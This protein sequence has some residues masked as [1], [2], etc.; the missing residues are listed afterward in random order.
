MRTFCT[1]ITAD[2][3]PKAI[4][5]FKSINKLEPGALLHIIVADNK[6]VNIGRFHEERIKIIPISDL[7]KYWL[8]DN[9]Y[10]KYAHIDLNFFR[11]SLKPIVINYLLEKGFE[12]VFYA[13]CDFYFF[14]DYQFLYDELDD[15]SVLLTP[16]WR[17]SDPLTDKSSFLA[18]FTS[19]VYSAGFIG[20]STRASP[21]LQWWANACHFMMGEQ[22]SLG[23]HDDQKYLDVLPVK[24]ESVKINRHRGCSLGAGNQQ[25]CERKLVSGEVLINGVYPIVSI[26]FDGLLIQEI[27]RGHDPLLLQYY[28][29]YKK[30]FEEDGARL[31]DFLA[32]VD[33]HANVGLL[34]RLKW[35]LNVRTRIK[36]VFYRLAARI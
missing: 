16:H 27:M 30:V 5:L 6:P 31:S 22:T 36:R 34:R 26:H 20:A 29:E 8:V 23:I 11:W 2:Y 15:C 35:K 19:G 25:E 14:S 33:T 17:N 24:F 28:E 13:D 9:L 10:K 3:Y 12:K 7:S 21:E 32:A 18:L 1:I 4:A